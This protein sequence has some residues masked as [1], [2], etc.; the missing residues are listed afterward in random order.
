MKK[1]TRPS[2][3]ILSL[4]RADQ[5]PV[6][7]PA[8]QSI[9]CIKAV[10]ADG[11]LLYS[12]LTGE[13]ILL[14]NG[15][16]P[17]EYLS[18][19]GFLVAADADEQGLC[20][21][22]R[23]TL[24]LF[25]S[26]KSSGLDTYTIL[27][28]SDC[29]A[30][31]F[32]CYESGCEKM[33]MSDNT[34]RLAADYIL[35]T[36]AGGAVKLRW[37]GG[38]PLFN[39]RAIDIICSCLKDA[40]KDF[41]SMMVSNGYL[42][43]EDLIHRST[44]L[45]KLENVQ[46]TLDGTEDVYNRRKAFVN[47]RDGAFSRVTGNIGRLLEAGIKVQIRLNTDIANIK[48][49]SELI[50]I[51][52]EKYPDRTMLRVYVTPLFNS[53]IDDDPERRSVLYGGL[54]ELENKALALGFARPASLPKGLK[55]NNCIADNEKHVVIL[56]DGRLHSC[57]HF[58]ETSSYGSIADETPRVNAISYWKQTYENLSDCSTCQLYPQCIRL[59]HCPNSGNFCHPEARQW[60]IEHIIA[61]MRAEYNQSK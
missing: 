9:Y 3:N 46:I 26:A 48:D 45:W 49:L 34:A 17:V 33:A 60:Q 10:V 19:H 58:N 52:N 20:D 27:T 32:Y 22:M 7:A 29:N 36:S 43:D 21:S 2:D 23:A 18:K 30:R 8:K 54:R 47:D 15:E 44:E 61:S 24:D 39:S 35:R 1:I 51:L 14:E 57:E 56:P 4:I 11:T 25:G 16:L 38:E 41:H 37:F 59:L 40:G 28:T 6:F 42:F 13:M 55:T 5:P 50:D 53:A 31:C 12:T